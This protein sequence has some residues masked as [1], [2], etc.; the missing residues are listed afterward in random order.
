MLKIS[1]VLLTSIDYKIRFWGKRRESVRGKRKSVTCTCWIGKINISDHQTNSFVMPYL[2]WRRE[3]RRVER[4]SWRKPPGKR[5][6]KWR[7]WRRLD[8]RRSMAAW[9]SKSGARW[10]WGRIRPRKGRW[11][12]CWSRP[13]LRQ[14]SRPPDNAPPTWRARWL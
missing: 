6:S 5:G 7:E 3:R 8:R 9:S 10:T 1:V 13:G 4:R 11:I 2:V 14:T 12:R